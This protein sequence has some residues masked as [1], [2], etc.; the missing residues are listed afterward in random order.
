MKIVN[1]IPDAVGNFEGL[2]DFDAQVHEVNVLDSLTKTIVHRLDRTPT[3]LIVFDKDGFVD[4]HMSGKT[5]TDV[6]IN[7]SLNIR[8]K[9]FI[10]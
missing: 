7:R 5:K 8:V 4:V 3:G 9:F 6:V 2:A 10:Y 1:L